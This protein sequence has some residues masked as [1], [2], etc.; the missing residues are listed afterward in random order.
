MP[1]IIKRILQYGFF[2]ALGIFLIWWQLK[3]MSAQEQKEFRL[4]L[5]NANYLIIIPVMAMSLLCN[6]SRAIRWK[7]LIEPLGYHPKNHNTFFAVMVGYLANSALPRLGE[8]L[9]CTILGK[10]EKIPAGPLVGTILLERTVDLVTYALLIALTIAIQADVIGPK[11]S[12]IINE[13]GSGSHFP[14][15]LK[16]I[17]F[18]AAVAAI[19]FFFR[20]LFRKYP[21]NR[22]VG[23]IRHIS[24][25]VA[26]GFATIKRIKNKGWFL[27]H[28]LFIWIMYTLQIYVGFQALEATSHLSLAAA[29][30]LLTVGTLAMIVTP[31]GIGAFPIAIAGVIALYGVS[32]GT[33]ISFGWFIWGFTTGFVILFGTLSLI[34][35]P[36]VNKQ[37][38]THPETDTGSTTENIQS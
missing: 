29:C 20:W 14:Y 11:V 32:S 9:K 31:N 24:K 3:D 13:I 12:D 1:R 28:T 5:S 7:I 26:A 34:L 16:I 15:W 4:A 19:V 25:D 10:Y 35:I 22:F 8:V 23:R 27:A 21:N 38:M 18:L 37:K 30:S 33:G 6:I 2:P 17:I 36:I